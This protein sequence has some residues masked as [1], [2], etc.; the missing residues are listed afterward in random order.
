MAIDMSTVTQI[1]YNNKE[2]T[3]IEDSLGNILWQK[4]TPQPYNPA[5]LYYINGTSA[6]KVD[7][8]NKT[9]TQYTTVGGN[10][11]IIGSRIAEYNGKLYATAGTTSA[12]DNYLV[13]IDDDNQT[14]TYTLSDVININGNS[15]FKIGNTNY[16]G[17]G[18]GLST[19]IYPFNNSTAKWTFSGNNRIYA[20]GVMYFNNKYFTKRYNN[21]FAEYD[22]NTDSWANNSMAM[23]VTGATAYQFWVWDGILYYSSGTTQYYLNN[24]TGTS[25]NQISTMSAGYTMQFNGA[26]TFTDGTSAYMLGGTSTGG[27]IY[28]RKENLTGAHV[29]WEEYWTLPSGYNWRGDY[30]INKHGTAQLAQNA[31]PKIE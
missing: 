20:N 15:S 18:N 3:K 23:P 24:A 14:I 10:S 29:A 7:M 6:Y 8:I 25:W 30:F 2:V 16:C 19:T 1:M 12:A 28:K 17:E 11:N 27:T 9:I 31:R 26:R 13:D 21:Y 4:Y 22:P 5:I